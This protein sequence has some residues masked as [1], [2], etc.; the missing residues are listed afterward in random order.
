MCLMLSLIFT[1]IKYRDLLEHLLLIV[2]PGQFGTIAAINRYCHGAALALRDRKRQQWSIKH[3]TH[4]PE[5]ECVNYEF[6]H[7][8]ALHGEWRKWSGQVKVSHYFMVDGYKHGIHKTWRDDGTPESLTCYEYDSR[9]RLSVKWH[10]DVEAIN[11]SHGKQHGDWIRTDDM[12]YPDTS[13]CFH[14][15]VLH[16]TS[17]KRWSKGTIRTMSE[18]QNGK[19]HGRWV[20]CT[21]VGTLSSVSHYRNGR[22]HGEHIEYWN[23]GQMRRRCC[24]IDGRPH[25]E[26]RGWYD[27]GRR[28]RYSYY[29]H[30]QLRGEDLR[31]YMNGRIYMRR[32]FDRQGR[33]Q[34]TVRVWHDNGVLM[35]RSQRV[36]DCYH[37]IRMQWLK[38]GDFLCARLYERGA[39]VATW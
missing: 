3:V 9:H 1:D 32:Y 27:N 39:V 34:G 24:F 30:G 7:S 13:V 17:I 4:D 6:I 12:Y 33:L 15:G 20:S 18:Y 16:G 23:N 36:N 28:E 25:G 37:G 5:G 26:W 35:E 19:R 2:R 10:V 8:G 11:Y 31:W 22:L 14:N 21:N 29:V 38:S